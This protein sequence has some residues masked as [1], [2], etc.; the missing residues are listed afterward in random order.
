MQIKKFFYD[1]ETTGTDHRRNGI[2]QIAGCIEIDGQIVEE[3]NF[4]VAPNPKATIEDKALEVG[5]VALE[6]IQAYE[7]MEK[8]F[9]KVKALLSRHCDPYNKSDK[10]FLIGYNNGP[11]DDQFLRAW[12]LQND[13]DFFGAW[14]FSGNLDAMTLANQ[15]LIYKRHAMKDFELHTVA[16][17]LGIEVDENKLHDANYDIFLTREIYN[18]CTG[19]DLM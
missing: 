15:H 16:T 11:F 2:H 14:F 1:L 4:K 13:D 8:V 5:C 10:M 6:Q 9:R 17:T 12:F 19:A 3:F 18:I 7:P